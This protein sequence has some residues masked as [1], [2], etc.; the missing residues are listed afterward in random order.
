[1]KTVGD[2]LC[3]E[4]KVVY[5]N[6]MEVFAAFLDRVS[7]IER[8]MF[9]PLNNNNMARR[10]EIFAELDN[11]LATHAPN[12]ERLREMEDMALNYRNERN[13]RAVGIPGR[14]DLLEQIRQHIADR[15]H[16]MNLNVNINVAVEN[17][18]MNGGRRRRSGL[19]K[20]RKA[21][22]SRKGRKGRKGR[23]SYHRR[24]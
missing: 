21:R 24:N 12:I 1:M 14:V 15:I 22:K 8:R 6:R 10:N 7:D 4:E 17:E 13:N 3:I 20:T 5:I 19:R 2:G 11:I 23:K 18:N 9:E 16:Q